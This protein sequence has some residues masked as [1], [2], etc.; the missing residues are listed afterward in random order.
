MPATDGYSPRIEGILPSLRLLC[1]CRGDRPVAL[2]VARI[3]LIYI[4]CSCRCRGASSFSF[5][6]DGR[7]L[8]S[9][10]LDGT[11]VL[12]DMSPYITPQT[13]NADFDGNGVVDFADFLEFAANFGLN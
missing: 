12:W 10:D 5:S 13:A 7:I 3:S 1:I 8:A 11:I 4:T 9:A 2:L 6:P